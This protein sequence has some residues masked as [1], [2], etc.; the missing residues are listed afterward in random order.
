MKKKLG[1]VFFVSL[2]GLAVSVTVAVCGGAGWT[3]LLVGVFAALFLG[4]VVRCLMLEADGL[5][6]HVLP[7]CHAWHPVDESKEVL[8]WD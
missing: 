5:F 6:D 8:D 7:G 2:L 4:C 1:I 3:G